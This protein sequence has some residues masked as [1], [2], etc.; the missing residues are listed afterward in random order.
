MRVGKVPCETEGGCKRAYKVTVTTL[1][2]APTL[3]RHTENLSGK[4][5]DTYQ[6]KHPERREGW[7]QTKN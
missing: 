3:H 4:G 6:E 2:A 1:W 7:G 5:A